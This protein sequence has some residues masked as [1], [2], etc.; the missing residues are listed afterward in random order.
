MFLAELMPRLE[1][2]VANRASTLEDFMSG[3]WPN[4]GNSGDHA[5][6]RPSQATDT[7]AIAIDVIGSV[8]SSA[9]RVDFE[10]ADDVNPR[11]GQPASEYAEYVHFTGAAT[12][13]ALDR[14]RDQFQRGITDIIEDIETAAAAILARR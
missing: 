4:T 5:D 14:A 3:S 8:D 10:I 2:I 6:G 13:S 12:G 1:S 7:S 9:I 11:T